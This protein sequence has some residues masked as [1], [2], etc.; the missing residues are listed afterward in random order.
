MSTFSTCEEL[1]GP[2][3]LHFGRYGGLRQD[4]MV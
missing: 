3:T 4:I 2:V 1:V